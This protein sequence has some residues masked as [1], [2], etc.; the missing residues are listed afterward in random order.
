MLRRHFSSVER[1]DQ[2]SEVTVR[3]RAKLVVYR[4]SLSVPTQPVPEDVPLPFVTHA[5]TSIFVATT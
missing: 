1:F 2:E 3:E 4:D 5:R